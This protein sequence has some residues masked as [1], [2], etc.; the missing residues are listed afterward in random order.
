MHNFS[1]VVLLI[2]IIFGTYAYFN[3]PIEEPAW[4]N[5]IPGFAFSPYQ[6]GQSPFL[7]K[8]P[9]PEQI[10]R[11]LELLSGKAHAIRT[12][13]VDKVFAQ[14]PQL[15]YKYKIN[16]AL[17]AWLDKDQ[18]RN[19]AE[20]ERFI[21]LIE[22]PPYNIVR[23][24]V[25][26]EV[27]LR[28]D[29][30]PEQLIAVLQDVRAKT[31]VPVGTAEPW[32]VWI[33]HPELVDEVDFIAVHMLP[34][35]EG[36]ALEDSIEY[37]V[38]KM[39]LLRSTFPGKPI[40]I[41]EVG[42]PSKG[43]A[44]KKAEAS[45]ANQAIFMRRFIQRAQQE[46]YIFY[47]MEAFDQ[48]WKNRLEGSVGGHWGLYD[49]D[50][51]LKFEQQTPIIALP[52]WRFLAAASALLAVAMIA[53]LLI[54][55]GALRKRG[56]SFLAVLAFLIS[57]LVIWMIYDYSS[58]YHNWVGVLVGILLLLGV[59]GVIVVI[60]T[61]AHE[62]AEAIWYHQR[63]RPLIEVP[64]QQGVCPFVSIHVPAYNEPPEMMKET[65]LALS[66][67][68]YPCFEVLVIDN[69]TRDESVWRPVEDF[70]AELGE[71]FRFYHVS[72]LSG[73]KAGAL[74]YALQRT[75]E[76]AEIIAVIDS[77][78]R[79]NPDWLK[80]MVGQFHEPNVAIVQAPQDYWDYS[81]NAFKA[82][83]YAEYK[84][85]FHIGM[86]TRNER[87]AIIQHG[88]MTMVRH[89]VLQA[90]GGWGETTITEDAELGLRIFEQ[91]YAAVYSEHSF[92][93]G[94]MPDT[95]IDYKKQ[96]YRWAYGA[97]QILREHAGALLDWNKT[98]LKPGQRYHFFAGWLP[99]IADGFNYIFTVLAII[100]TGLM[101]SD[102]VQYNAPDWMIS[103]IPIV[104][105]GFKM[106]KMLVL[107]MGHVGANLRTA[108]AAAISGLALS[109]TIAKAVLWGLFVGRKMPFLRTPKL[110][111]S[112]NLW[113]ALLDAYEE[114]LMAAILLTAAVL[115]Y[116]KFGFDTFEI[117][118]WFAVLLVQSIPYFASLMLSII[119][120]IPNLRGDWVRFKS[121]LSN[122]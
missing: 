55:S 31:S 71:R 20:I 49:V 18:A 29:L 53:F 52:E 100:W 19:T 74:N 47:M 12:Y 66:Q 15:A 39:N 76:Q 35:W 43:R 94:V 32:H 65:L 73:F 33:K 92:G 116:W 78:Y 23:A 34:F 44:I 120:A 68:D 45:R 118:L 110:A 99:W 14:I 26:N 36:I 86:V 96:R 122:Q 25:G 27:L 87:N 64:V 109:H 17:G 22:Q 115:L 91:G 88:T 8:Y 42:W 63:R 41:T 10:D 111:D 61:E 37:I 4:P 79:V 56:R 90:V 70:C 40:V 38:D 62:W 84:G 102:P 16:L 58:E 30:S 60:L 101:L 51:Q 59:V 77:D 24:I 50:R 93:K 85:F 112:H 57:S 75:A 69:N 9:T 106:S 121:D 104:F 107:Y 117:N 81:Q 67:L 95:Y 2:S 82:M 7:E 72:P 28:E 114:A 108:L 103:I 97:M 80:R 5:D 21:Q 1:V 3:Q 11:D 119:S 6:K 105:F 98:Q 13:T 54:D 46:K 83:C 89:R 48:P 113:Q